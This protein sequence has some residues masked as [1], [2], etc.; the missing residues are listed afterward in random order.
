MFFFYADVVIWGTLNFLNISLSH[1]TFRQI[2]GGLVLLA[3]CYLRKSSIGSM[4]DSW[5]VSTTCDQAKRVVCN[6]PFSFSRHPYYW[7]SM[8]ELVGLSLALYFDEG[9]YFT[10]C[11]YFPLLIFRCVLE[12][13]FLCEKFPTEYLEYKSKVLFF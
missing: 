3:G 5:G 7:A 4:G 12:E 10:I 1:V 2:A 8:L 6:G 13:R 9:I 11:V